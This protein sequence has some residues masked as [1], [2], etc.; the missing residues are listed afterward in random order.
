MV[1]VRIV[2]EWVDKAGEDFAFALVNLQEEK[3]FFSQICFHFHQA[4]E[5]YLKAYIVAWGLDFR[6][7][8]DL[9]LLQKICAARDPAA[10]ELRESCAFLTA[11]YVDTRYP[12]HWPTHYSREEAQRAYHSAEIVKHWV[13]RRLPSSGSG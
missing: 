9:V 13:E 12:V 4:A 8:H 5:K 3:P 11:F 2:Q 7:V 10:E 1:D 6:K